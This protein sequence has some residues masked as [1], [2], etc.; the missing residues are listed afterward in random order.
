MECEIQRRRLFCF[1]CRDRHPDPGTLLLVFGQ[2]FP[3]PD[4]A[5]EPAQLA[6]P[7]EPAQGAD[8]PAYTPY[9]PYGC[10]TVTG[11]TRLG[12]ERWRVTWCNICHPATAILAAQETGARCSDPVLAARLLA[13]V[14]ALFKPD[15]TANRNR[16]LELQR[17]RL[18]DVA[19]DESP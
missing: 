1:W 18:P 19:R 3:G 16:L 15:A 8:P 12:G 13:E 4:G 11:F 14:L 7:R 5:R 17:S 6:D 2:P 10:R 9:C